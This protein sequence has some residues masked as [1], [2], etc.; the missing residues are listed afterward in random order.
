MKSQTFFRLSLVCQKKTETHSSFLQ[1]QQYAKC[2]LISSDLCQ[3]L[4]SPQESF[5]CIFSRTCLLHVSFFPWNST[6]FPCEVDFF[7]QQKYQHIWGSIRKC[8]VGF[9]G[10]WPQI[11]FSPRMLPAWP[12]PHQQLE[13]PQMPRCH[14]SLV[15]KYR[16]PTDLAIINCG[17]NV[18]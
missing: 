7:L 17:L 10:F 15:V 4:Y 1:E 6:F 9:Y 2:D 8:F 13:K 12:Q 14:K 18:F 5:H 11:I 16:H 3:C